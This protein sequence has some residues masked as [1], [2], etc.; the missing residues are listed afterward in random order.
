MLCV[1]AQA[2]N[3]FSNSPLHQQQCTCSLIL[4]G[5]G[6]KKN[7]WFQGTRS[8]IG[9]YS[10]PAPSPRPSNKTGSMPASDPWLTRDLWH[11]RFSGSHYIVPKPWPGT[12]WTASLQQ[13][14]LGY[15]G[16]S[17]GIWILSSLNYFQHFTTHRNETLEPSAQLL[18]K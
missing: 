18:G 8:L 9:H 2:I 4:Q 11:K 3:K 14:S 16:V 12:V 7:L 17:S 15:A 10:P 6:L 5:H 13:H 1:T